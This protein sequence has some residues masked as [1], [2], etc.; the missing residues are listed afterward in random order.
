MPHNFLRLLLLLFVSLPVLAADCD[1]GFFD[2]PRYG[3]PDY[4]ESIVAIDLDGDERLDLATLGES[5]TISVLL[6]KL[7][8]FVHGEPIMLP[9]EAWAILESND[10]IIA[11][12][13]TAIMSVGQTVTKT[14][15][16]SDAFTYVGSADFNGDG[17]T[18]AAAITFRRTGNSTVRALRVFMARH[19]GTFTDL[20]PVTLARPVYDMTMGDVNADGKT[21]V[22]LADNGTGL[23]LEGNGDGTFK[24]A[25]ELISGY[26]S[27]LYVTAGDFDG[28]GRDDVLANSTLVLS[29]RPSLPVRL[30]STLSGSIAA[31]V[32][33]DGRMD[34][35]ALHEFAIGNGDGT[36]TR[37]EHGGLI[38]P[39]FGGFAWADLNGDGHLDYAH[40][41][42]LQDVAIYYGQPGFRLESGHVTKSAAFP[43]ITPLAGDL[44]GDGRDDIVAVSA[45]STSVYLAEPDGSLRY[46]SFVQK[47]ASAAVLGDVNGDG[48]LDLFLS[49]GIALGRGDGTFSEPVYRGA[50]IE[51]SGT[52][53]VADIN[54]DGKLDVVSTSRSLTGGNEGRIS[55]SINSGS[56]D[57]TAASL[58][59]PVAV[60]NAAVAHFNGDATQDVVFVGTVDGRYEL[61]LLDGVSRQPIRIATRVG[62]EA[63]AAADVDG[64]GFT[65]IVTLSQPIDDLL[66]FGGNGNGTFRE[67]R[68]INVPDAVDSGSL[69]V[70][71]FTNDGRPDVIVSARGWDDAI[72]FVQQSDG[73]FVETAHTPDGTSTAAADFDGDGRLDFLRDNGSTGGFSIFLN[74]C[75]QELT[76]VPPPILLETSADSSTLGQAVTLTATLDRTAKGTVTFYAKVAGGYPWVPLATATVTA[77]RATITTAALGLGTHEIH[78]VYSGGGRF[79]RSRSAMIEQFVNGGQ[80]RRAVRQ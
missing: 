58:T 15:I 50:R 35:F 73:G 38:G 19:D 79:S 6:N 40:G 63:I 67:P 3:L 49:G 18:D 22:L 27:I 52:A 28:D 41:T 29:T 69:T 75:R 47:D 78:A 44:N 31:D 25:R 26:G 76:A 21:D 5:S 77:G 16:S 71:D 39:G 46:V 43:F 8:G 59:V 53:S 51:S 11:I 70:A 12:H 33:S 30:S 36:F 42:A 56:G 13:P 74:R 10:G 14:D 66:I 68:R 64:D 20:P 34:L 72:L 54:S 61:H 17:R 55:I 45:T 57:F 24:A 32:N 4:A 9:A 65:D 62:S 2:V 48:D 1:P 60:R 23:V 80:R 7:Q 37:Y